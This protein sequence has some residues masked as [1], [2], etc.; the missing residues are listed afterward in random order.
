LC[1]SIFC[2][3]A[4]CKKKKHALIYFLFFFSLYSTIT[5]LVTGS[6][7]GIKL[8]AKPKSDGAKRYSPL[9]LVY[10]ENIKASIV[11]TS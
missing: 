1:N 4:K 10:Q 3:L 2:E 6:V 9:P 7:H 8:W 5:I 11:A